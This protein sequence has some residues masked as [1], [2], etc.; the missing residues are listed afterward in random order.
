MMK[1]S[2]PIASVLRVVELEP[3]IVFGRSTRFALHS[4]E[5]LMVVLVSDSLHLFF[6]RRDKHSIRHVG[7]EQ[8]SYFKFLGGTERR[9]FRCTKHRN[10]I[11]VITGR[12]K[13]FDE[14]KEGFSAD[15]FFGVT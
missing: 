15:G 14:V 7:V 11:S 8:P 4:L 13:E 6:E 2:L 12:G 1:G 10:G 3:M 9:R 5:H